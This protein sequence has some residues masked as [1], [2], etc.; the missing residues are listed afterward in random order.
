MNPFLVYKIRSWFRLPITRL[1]FRVLVM[2]AWTETIH[3]CSGSEVFTCN[4]F[5]TLKNKEN[6]VVIC[7]YTYVPNYN[8]KCQLQ[9]LTFWTYLARLSRTRS[10]VIVYYIL[11]IWIQIVLVTFIKRLLGKKD[12]PFLWRSFSSRIKLYISGSKVLRG[13]FKLHL[14]ESPF[15]LHSILSYKI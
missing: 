15:W 3:Y 10:K 11:A 13:S 1:S 6:W 9:K 2:K 14:L 8:F 5:Q 7:N 4:H 12:A